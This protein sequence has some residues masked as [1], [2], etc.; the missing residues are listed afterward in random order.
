MAAETPQV[1][2]SVAAPPQ[3]C[4]EFPSEPFSTLCTN[5]T[6]GWPGGQVWASGTLFYYRVR[7]QKC[8]ADSCPGKPWSTAATSAPN[9][10]TTARVP[11]ARTGWYRPCGQVVS[12]GPWSCVLNSEAVYLGD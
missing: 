11:V 4:S 1:P 3:H 10:Q 2:A 8:V 7:L 5:W 9:T 6:G 12:G